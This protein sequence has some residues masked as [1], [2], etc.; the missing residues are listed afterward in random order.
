MTASSLNAGT[1]AIEQH[2]AAVMP[3]NG[4]H[5]SASATAMVEDIFAT[6]DRRG[7][8]QRNLFG[9]AAILPV[10][11]LAGVVAIGFRPGVTTTGLPVAA[12][13][14]APDISRPATA[15]SPITFDDP[16]PMGEWW[17]SMILEMLP[18]L[19]L[20]S[21]IIG[22]S[23]VVGS[24]IRGTRGSRPLSTGLRLF[25]GAALGVIALLSAW[26]M[27][28]DVWFVAS[29]SMEPTLPVSSQ[30]FTTPIGSLEIGDVVVHGTSPVSGA[31]VAGGAFEE[32][33][34]GVA[35]IRRIVGLAGD[36][37]AGRDGQLFINGQIVDHPRAG[38]IPDFGPVAVADGEV[39][40]MGDNQPMSRDSIGEGPYQADS[41]FAEVQSIV[42]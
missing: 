39:F 17:G 23:L 15:A 13:D 33:G 25:G 1:A 3:A 16:T 8:R 37:V 10:L 11:A 40:L 4:G 36:E 42:G 21:A 20:V 19:A 6:V 24:K 9:L 2:L 31:S 18:A 12:Q 35:G 7:H 34:G 26:L 27:T 22:A 32:G 5:H 38:G 28:F 29:A 41:V 14:L 30:V